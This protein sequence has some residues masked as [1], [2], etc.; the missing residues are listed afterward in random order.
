MLPCEYK[1]INEISF[2]IV[3]KDVLKKTFARGDQRHCTDFNNKRG[4]K[5]ID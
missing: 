5:E 1:N 4:Q 3:S 2:V